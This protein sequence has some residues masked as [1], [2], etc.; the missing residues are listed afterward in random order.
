M[1][2]LAFE[3]HDRPRKLSKNINT[4][5]IHVSPQRG[6]TKRSGLTS[7]CFRVGRQLIGRLGWVPGNSRIQYIERDGQIFFGLKNGQWKLCG[8]CNGSLCGRFSIAGSYFDNPPKK[9]VHSTEIPYR[10]VR[11]GGQ[12]FLV[13]QSSETKFG[14]P[15]CAGSKP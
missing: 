13:I 6:C 7:V 5:S 8:E 11:S 10:I 14:I 3:F 9:V 12:K 1:K 2:K 15:T 4:V